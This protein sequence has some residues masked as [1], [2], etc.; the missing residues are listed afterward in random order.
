MTATPRQADRVPDGRKRTLVAE[1]HHPEI[2]RLG[3]AGLQALR[4]LLRDT[5]R[6]TARRRC[7]E[8][9]GRQEARGR[10]PARDDSGT[11]I[12]QSLSIRALRRLGGEIERRGTDD[13]HAAA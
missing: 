10:E 12:K 13:V 4:R 1:T 2:R 7:R 8:M 9:R 11:A 5:A 3:L 6:D